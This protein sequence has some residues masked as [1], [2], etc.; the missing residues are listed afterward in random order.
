MVWQ[1]VYKYK[2]IKANTFSERE[3]DESKEEHSPM[4]FIH[5]S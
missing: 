3:A 4:H 2:T 1:M 5:L